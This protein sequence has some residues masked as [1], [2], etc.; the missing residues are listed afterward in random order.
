MFNASGKESG[1]NVL[2][3]ASDQ[4][5]S[6]L[7]GFLKSALVVS[8]FVCSFHLEWVACLEDECI[9]FLEPEGFRLASGFLP[10]FACLFLGNIRLCCLIV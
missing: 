10:L 4:S 3:K 1:R 6:C 5:F 9:S 2:E 7:T 8:T